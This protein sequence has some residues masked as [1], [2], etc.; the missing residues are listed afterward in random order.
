MLVK[1]L[2]HY[3]HL[4]GLDVT[5][6]TSNNKKD[7]FS[8][9]IEDFPVKRYRFLTG[10]PTFFPSIQFIR[11]VRHQHRAILHVH[12]V[13]H[14]FPLLLCLFKTGDQLFVLHSHYHR[15]G[16]SSAKNAIFSIYKRIISILILPRVNVVIANS[17]HEKRILQEDFPTIK[18]IALVPE[19]LPLD[20]LKQVRWKPEIPERILWVGSLRKYKNI[21]KLLYAFKLLIERSKQPI[22]LVIIGNGPEKQN[23]IKLTLELG[24]DDKVIW[25]QDLPRKDL[26][27]EY[28]K[29][30]VFVSL[31]SME[32]F[33][34][35]VY[36]AAIIGIPTIVAG[37]SFF[38]DL[39][40]AGAV[41]GIYQVNPESIAKEI[42]KAINKVPV[43]TRNFGLEFQTTEQY[44]TR[45]A[46]LYE[47]LYSGVK[48]D[49][50][51]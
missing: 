24:I 33:G 18:N 26:L 2:C 47:A 23:L 34:R 39:L 16:Q 31:S 51:Q 50:F 43:P 11:D 9:Q 27:I 49:C 25:K 15:Y 28:S 46:T 29:S 12:N 21:D 8:Q 10:D 13:H 41:E 6:Y 35:S 1:E 4:K 30:K 42:L 3:L 17:I 48:N 40:R 22:R 32:S 7:S 37:V 14:V 20:E 44:A 19:G 36:E 38:S 5:V 45:I